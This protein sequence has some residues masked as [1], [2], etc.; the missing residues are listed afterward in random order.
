MSKYD[1]LYN[2]IKKEITTEQLLPGAKLPSIRKA[3]AIYGVSRTTVQNAYFALA[4]D[5]FIIS[6]PQSGYYIAYKKAKKTEEKKQTGKRNI[7][8]DFKSGNADKN[9]FEFNLWRRYMKNALR[10]D[11]KLLSY[12][13]VQGEYELRDVLSDYIREK[14]NVISSP[15]RIVIGTGHQSLL[16]ILCSL[17]DEKGTVSFPD[18]SFVQG[19]SLFGDYG[20]D[21][22]YRYKD[23]DIIYVSPSHMNKRGDV[24]PNRR[25]IELVEHSSKNKSL[26]IEDDYESDFQY[27]GTPAPSLHALAGGGNV[28]YISSFSNLLLPSIRISFMVL[29]EELAEKYERELYKYNQTAGKTEQIALSQYIR[30]GHL[31]AQIRKTRRFYTTKTKNF[32]A[33]LS[34][35]FKNAKI[36]ISE[37]ALKIIMRIPFS[38]SLDVFEENGIAVL[39][40]SYENGILKMILNPSAVNE[41]AFEAAIQALKQVLN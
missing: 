39:T 17:I 32:A 9:S 22:K 7:L 40:E 38:K 3:A 6:E 2:I 31:K 5:G 36:E 20:F 35:E 29:T 19:A 27:S 15:N 21:V 28:V 34:E 41:D 13:E 10:Q 18:K 30:D 25:R 4:A 37:N 26:I 1:E 16:G 23:A 14:R 8:Y 33:L 12:G 24:M 11:E